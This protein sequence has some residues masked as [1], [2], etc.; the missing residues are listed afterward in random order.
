VFVLHGRKIR[1]LTPNNA[2]SE[3]ILLTW[4]FDLSIY[5]MLVSLL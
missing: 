1:S 2:K 3:M 4:Y 5:N